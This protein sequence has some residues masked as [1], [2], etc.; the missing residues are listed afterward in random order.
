MSTRRVRLAGGPLDGQVRE[1]EARDG[2]IL[3]FS[4]SLPVSDGQEAAL[5]YAMTGKPEGGVPVYEFC[6][7]T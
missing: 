4:I 5:V 2:F 7:T 1:L 3:P 6:G